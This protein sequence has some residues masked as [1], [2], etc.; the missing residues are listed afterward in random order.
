MPAGLGI[1][2]TLSARVVLSDGSADTRGVTWE[3]SDPSLLSLSAEGAIAVKVGAG[4]GTAFVTA[5]SEG[6]GTITGRSVV[7]VTRD[8]FLSLDIRPIVTATLDPG[9]FPH[10]FD[11]D[12]VTVDRGGETIATA[13]APWSNL[14]LRLPAAEGYRVVVTR[15]QADGA[16]VSAALSN[17]AILPNTLPG[18]TANLK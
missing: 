11:V 14:R 4:P 12:R 18:A 6:D 2:A 10:R 1:A 17:L 8:G 13:R 9:A 5:R 3:V 7:T 15:V 16:T